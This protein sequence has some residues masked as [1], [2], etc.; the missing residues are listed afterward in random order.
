MYTGYKCI[1]IDAYK[2]F[3]E[4]YFFSSPITRRFIIYLFTSCYK[5]HFRCVW[6]VFFFKKHQTEN[7]PCGLFWNPT[8]TRHGNRVWI[9]K[10]GIN[11]NSFLFRR[12]TRKKK[13]RISLTMHRIHVYNVD[14]RRSYQFWTR[15]RWLHL[16][17]SLKLN[18]LL[19]AYFFFVINLF[20]YYLT[21]IC[22][23]CL[24]CVCFYIILLDVF[25]CRTYNL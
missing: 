25:I 2:N 17:T 16:P 24:L 22:L 14:T 9:N 5:M 4:P 7:H 15:R 20:R 1:G 23:P 10:Y 12:T 6:I 13:T 11:I 19:R 18:E 8:P 21:T 3:I